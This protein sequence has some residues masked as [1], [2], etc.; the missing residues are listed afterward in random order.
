MSTRLLKEPSHE[1]ISQCAYFR[2]LHQGEPEG[3]DRRNWFAAE[4]ELMQHGLAEDGI[5]WG[6]ET[7]DF[8]HP[9]PS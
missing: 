2:W 9:A 1:E 5:D 6:R 4:T 7:A 3:Q 8:S